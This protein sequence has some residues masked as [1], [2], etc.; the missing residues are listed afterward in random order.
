MPWPEQRWLQTKDAV[1]RKY[2]KDKERK[3]KST[4]ISLRNARYR[5]FD[6]KRGQAILEIQR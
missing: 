2:G 4:N 1:E 6:K 3:D 5:G